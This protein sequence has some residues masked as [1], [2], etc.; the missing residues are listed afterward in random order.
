MINTHACQ[1]SHHIRQSHYCSLL[2]KSLNALLAHAEKIITL[3]H[4]G[5]TTL[6]CLAHCASRHD[7]QE[8]DLG[9]T[10]EE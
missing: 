4:A 1:Q 7:L 6:P 2:S 10:T 9:V 3:F 5:E 8:A